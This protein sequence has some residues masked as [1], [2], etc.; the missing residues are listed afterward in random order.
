MQKENSAKDAENMELR[1]EL[2]QLRNRPDPQEV[3]MEIQRRVKEHMVKLNKD[4]RAA[5]DHTIG[6]SGILTDLCVSTNR[7]S[8]AS[9]GSGVSG[10]VTARSSDIGGGRMR[11][12]AGVSGNTWSRGSQGKAFFYTSP[13]HCQNPV[14][15][16][17]HEYFHLAFC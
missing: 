15:L 5:M 11:Q 8:V 16:C 12:V 9:A 17:L 6:L 1:M 2:G 10:L 3:E 14:L 4:I 7:S 13:L